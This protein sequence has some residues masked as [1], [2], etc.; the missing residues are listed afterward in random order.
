LAVFQKHHL[1]LSREHLMVLQV[2]HFGTKFNN[3]KPSLL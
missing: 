2:L 1:M 3:K